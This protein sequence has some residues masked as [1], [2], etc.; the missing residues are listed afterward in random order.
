MTGRSAA[1]NCYSDRLSKS[2]FSRLSHF[3]QSNMGIKM[4]LSKLTMVES[5]LRK[6]LR[7][8]EINR[9]SDYCDFLFSNRG[10]E[11]E[12]KFFIDVI[13]T[14]KTE[15]FREPDHFE[16][17]V[18]KAVPELIA[19]KGVG[20]K[21]KLTFWSA[22]SSRG[23]EAY[24]IAI[25][26]D[27][28]Q[29]RYPGLNLDY[30][31]LGTDIS[32][33]VIDDAQRAIYNN[34]EIDPV[35]FDLR[36]KYFLR[37]KDPNKNLVRVVPKLRNKVQFRQLNLMN[38]DFKLREA[39]DIIFCRNVIIYFDRKTQDELI[40][41]LYQHLK[42]D[43]YLFMGHSEVLHCTDN[44]RLVPTAPSVYRKVI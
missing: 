35:P 27:E 41:R 24:T 30:S 13:T 32:R 16:Y 40:L 19:K 20:L 5:R 26:M 11:K 28:F 12:L 8:L 44:I 42:P 17:L 33:D 21:R 37:S 7:S 22:A 38:G 34:D 4:P 6:R 25:V 15:F 31:V 3:I 39:M 1:N 10:M 36:K 14:H 23:N 18:Q 43:G 2:D 9:F 29:K